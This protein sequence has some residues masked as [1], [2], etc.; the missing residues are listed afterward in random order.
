MKFKSLQKQLHPDKFSLK[1]TMEKSL[2]DQ[3]SSRLNE[4]YKV[5]RDAL[6]RGLYLVRASSLPTGSFL[7]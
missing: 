2:S 7:F 3:Q 5:L 4:A 1:S 6:P